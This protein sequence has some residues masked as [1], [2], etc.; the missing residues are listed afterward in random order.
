M[1]RESY[2]LML[3]RKASATT[4]AVNTAGEGTEAAKQKAQ[5]VQARDTH[6]D[7]LAALD[8]PQGS[9]RQEVSI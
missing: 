5:E 6:R 7:A 9:T 8:H 4:S 2:C 1:N 3:K